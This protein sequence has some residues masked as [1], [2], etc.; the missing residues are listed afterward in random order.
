MGEEEV[1]GKERRNVGG[2]HEAVVNG[3]KSSW[4]MNQPA[5]ILLG[6]LPLP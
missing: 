1:E 3:P 5:K 2:R 6:W 4:R